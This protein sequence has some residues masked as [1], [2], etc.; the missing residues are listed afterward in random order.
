LLLT[1]GSGPPFCFRKTS[2]YPGLAQ[3]VSG[4]NPVTA[5][6]FT[7]CPTLQNSYGPIAFAPDT[8]LKPVN[9][10][11]E[12]NSLP[13]SSKRTTQPCN[14]FFVLTPYEMF[15]QNRTFQAV[16]DYIHLVSSSF[17]LAFAILFS[18]QSLYYFA[19]GLSL[20]LELDVNV[21]QIPTPNPG[22]GTQDTR[23]LPSFI[24]LPGCHRLRQSIPAH[25]R[26]K[27]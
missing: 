21:T 6:A 17:H 26:L 16:P 18:F 27:G 5:S 7:P 20:Y 23:N 15:L 13:H 1:T 25:F 8:R 14:L 19:I 12:I 4:F 24:F 11:T 10:A 9:L 2:S 22:N 3:L